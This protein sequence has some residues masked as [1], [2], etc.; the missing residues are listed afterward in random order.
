MQTGSGGREEGNIAGRGSVM[1][2]KHKRVWPA[3]GIIEVLCD[4]S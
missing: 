1:T 3:V 2:G 4:W